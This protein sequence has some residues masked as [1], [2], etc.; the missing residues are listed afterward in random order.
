[1]TQ[2]IGSRIDILAIS[3]Y[4]AKAKKEFSNQIKLHPFFFVLLHLH[5]QKLYWIVYTNSLVDAIFF[6]EKKLC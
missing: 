5:L 6:L 3:N 4:P 1:M 2:K